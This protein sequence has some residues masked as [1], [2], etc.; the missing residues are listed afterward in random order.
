MNLLSG[1]VLS[2][3]GGVDDYIEALPRNETDKAITQVA[4]VT[5]RHGGLE[6]LI[7]WVD[8][9]TGNDAIS[10]RSRRKAFQRGSR[11]VARW[12]PER[13][14]EWAMANRGQPYAIDGPRIVAEQ[15]GLKDGRAAL[16]WVRDHPDQD[17]HYLAA[18]AAFL[19]W[20]KSDRDGAVEWLKS[21]DHTAF[22]DPAIVEY[23]KDLGKREPAEAIGWC[24][25]VL[26]ARQRLHCL[27]KVASLWYQR[28][29]L[30]AETWL[31][32]SP[33]DE[34]ARRAVRTPPKKRPALRR[35][36]D[37]RGAKDATPEGP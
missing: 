3:R 10:I 9:F 17:L 28:D 37:F 7:G 8:S 32:Q 20:L 2:G 1:W 11:M 26:E 14:A 6:A 29:A 23:G 5:L 33:L 22:H 16:E 19:S 24:E 34:E 21:E 4:G 18:R 27:K 36:E 30:A 25:R 35:P 12:N 13:A 15:W 31:Q